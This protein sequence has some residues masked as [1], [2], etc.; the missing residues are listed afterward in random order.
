MDNL[1]FWLAIVISL[2]VGFVIMALV[3][4]FLVPWQ[5]KAMKKRRAS[6]QV[7]FSIGESAGK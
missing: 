5:R 3:Q 6:A 1:P 2:S 7:N 4:L